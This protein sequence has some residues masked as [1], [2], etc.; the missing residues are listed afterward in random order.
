MNERKGEPFSKASPRAFLP[1]KG[2]IGAAAAAAAAADAGGNRT[3]AELPTWAL[4]DVSGG[5]NGY[6]DTVRILQELALFESA[7][8]VM[9][10]GP[11][12]HTSTFS[13]NLR[14]DR[15]KH[16]FF[17]LVRGSIKQTS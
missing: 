10:A 9:M 14:F 7:L 4:P 12:I 8:A 16:V 6:V 17:N 13:L 5:L 15:G 1:Y 2:G 3:K 11:F